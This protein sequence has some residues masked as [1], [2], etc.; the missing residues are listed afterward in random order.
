M[1]EQQHHKIYKKFQFKKILSV[2]FIMG[3]LGLTAVVLWPLFYT[4]D[5]QVLTESTNRTE[6]EANRENTEN[7]P[8]NAPAPQPSTQN[9]ASNTPQVK[10]VA[11]TTTPDTAPAPVHRT[12]HTPHTST[13]PAQ[14]ASTATTPSTISPEQQQA[15][16]ETQPTAMIKKL[17]FEDKQQQ[18]TVTA[19]KAEQNINHT[20]LQSAEITSDANASLLQ[21][22]TAVIDNLTKQ[23]DAQGNVYYRDKTGV[24]IASDSIKVKQNNHIKASGGVT[25]TSDGVI[26]KSQSATYTEKDGI[27][28]MTGGVTIQINR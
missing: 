22:D 11:D 12:A 19:H 27:L 10:T 21:A 5:I 3:G 16:S 20:R 13:T 2:L 26:A 7:T 15:I 28:T 9:Q 4:T 14:N 23:V 6:N 1:T 18:R 25:I 24:E 8:Q 17:S